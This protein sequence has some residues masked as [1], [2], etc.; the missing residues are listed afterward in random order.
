MLDEIV[1]EKDSEEIFY[2]VVT[3]SKTLPNLSSAVVANELQ[4]LDNMLS[5]YRG[6]MFS[7]HCCLP[8]WSK[9]MFAVKTS[10]HFECLESVFNEYSDSVSETML[11]VISN[12]A[13]DASL[14]KCAK[15]Y[16]WTV[17][18]GLEYLQAMIYAGKSV[19]DA[20]TVFFKEKRDLM[21][22][23]D[24]YFAACADIY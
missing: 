8:T 23:K 6:S 7:D 12:V 22:D 16:I 1:L 21:A 3:L 9:F 18:Y 19:E 24:V 2:S 13:N 14:S 20:Q 17:S 11:G 10:S 15:D 5:T 4:N